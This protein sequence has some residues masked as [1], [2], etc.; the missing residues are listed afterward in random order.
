MRFGGWG[1]ESTGFQDLLLGYLLE[2]RN[3][4]AL[5]RDAFIPERQTYESD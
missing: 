2:N 5:G 1:H 4:V 3:A